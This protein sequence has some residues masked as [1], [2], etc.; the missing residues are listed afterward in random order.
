MIR[1]YANLQ[2]IH[3]NLLHYA[4]TDGETKSFEASCYTDPLGIEHLTGSLAETIRFFG[5]QVGMHLRFVTKFDAV[6]ELLSVPHNGHTR[7]RFSMNVDTVSRRFEGG[8]ASVYKRI[9]AL[10]KMAAAGYPVG[11]VLAPIMP[12]EGWQEEYHDLLVR[13]AAAL[14]DTPCDLTFELITHR[15]TPGS[16]ETLLDWYPATKLDMDTE[17][18]ERKFGKFGAAKYVY[19]SVTM[20]QIKS[21]LTQEIAQL[22]PSARVLYFT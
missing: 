2:P 7:A 6:D 22:L 19:P 3:N 12:F 10:R 1:A 17:K 21:F 18:R 15:F 11:V 5:R 8:T 9:A 20:K 16:R 14:A 13:I 4:G